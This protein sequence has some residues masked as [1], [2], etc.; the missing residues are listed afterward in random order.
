MTTKKRMTKLTNANS[1]LSS[2]GWTEA[3]RDFIFWKQA[4]GLA[5]STLHEYETH[6]QRFFTRFDCWQTDNLRSSVLEHMSDSIKPAT[7]NLR[8]T[9]LRAFFKW[10]ISEGLLSLNPLEGFKLRKAEP[11]IVELP[12]DTLQRLLTLPDQTTYAGLRDYVLMLLTFDTGIRPKEAL[13]LAV[14]DVDLR[15]GIVNVR[16]DVAKTRTTRSMPI[17]SQ[18]AEAIRKLIRVRPDEWGEDVPIFCSNT[19]T[20]MTRH[21]WGDRMELYSKQLGVKIR[22]Y[23]LR[24]SFAVMYLRNGGHAFGLQ[25]T[26]GHTDM[27]MTKRYVHLTGQD[28]QHVHK[29]ASPLNNLVAAKKRSRVRKIETD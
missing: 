26:M 23:D 1:R 11:R 3:L 10:S 12:E 24:H 20:P 27:N 13:S 5:K 19:G 22:P 29:S 16:A 8:L 18:T 17:L 21:T 25:R 4:Q 15:H 14:H 2:I 6:I 28:L 7:F 9:Y